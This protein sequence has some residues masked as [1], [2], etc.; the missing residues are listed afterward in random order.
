MEGL[1]IVHLDSLTIF[2][3]KGI[4]IEVDSYTILEMPN[5]MGGRYC[6]RDAK[7]KNAVINV[8]GK[9]IRSSII[10][11]FVIEAAIKDLDSRSFGQSIAHP[12]WE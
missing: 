8:N 4:R 10:D 6:I 12:A 3:F 9:I 1:R 11:H 5:S 7:I 2:L